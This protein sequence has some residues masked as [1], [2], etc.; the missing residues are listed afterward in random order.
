MF[1]RL[2][3]LL[4]RLWLMQNPVPASRFCLCG[5]KGRGLGD[6]L[7]EMLIP[8]CWCRDSSGP[9]STCRFRSSPANLVG[10]EVCLQPHVKQLP[11]AGTPGSQSTAPGVAVLH[12]DH[13]S[14]WQGHYGMLLDPWGPWSD[15]STLGDGGSL[16]GCAWCSGAVSRSGGNTMP[17]LPWEGRFFFLYNKRFFVAK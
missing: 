15:Q 17:S 13:H 2:L 14:S 16:P 6:I 9:Q 5:G 10:G 12:E 11:K 3:A 1:W 8:A 4:L 7:S